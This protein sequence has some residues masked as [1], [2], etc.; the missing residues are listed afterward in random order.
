LQPTLQALQVQ[1]DAKQLNASAA[2]KIVKI[3]IRFRED[4]ALI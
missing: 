1:N 3:P 2:H 4:I